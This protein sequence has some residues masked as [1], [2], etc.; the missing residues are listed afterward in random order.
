[1]QSVIGT[2]IAPLMAQHAK[3]PHLI[4][5]I[6]WERQITSADSLVTIPLHGVKKLALSRFY[7]DLSH[8]LHLQLPHSLRIASFSL[9]AFALKLNLLRRHG[10]LATKRSR[11][12]Q[13]DPDREQVALLAI[14]PVDEKTPLTTW[15]EYLLTDISELRQG[16]RPLKMSLTATPRGVTIHG[17]DTLRHD[18]FT[19]LF[20]RAR[21]I[22]SRFTD[23]GLLEHAAIEFA[24][25]PKTPTTSTEETALSSS[26]IVFH[27]HVLPDQSQAS[28]PQQSRHQL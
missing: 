4:S 27:I 11:N 7:T 8:E 14:T 5:A 3:H 13:E 6:Q 25:V 21:V 10:Q 1:M 17:L 9:D 23:G 24:V 26:A 19:Y 12:L 22:A 2:V 28:H 16:N 15:Q 18:D 20:E